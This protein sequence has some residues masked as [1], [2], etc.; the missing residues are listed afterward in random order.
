MSDRQLFAYLDG[1]LAGYFS[2]TA[3]G[4]LTFDYDD[5][6]RSRSGSTPLSLSMPLATTRHRKRA[7]LPWLEGLLPDSEEALRAL[8]SRFHTSSRNP[9]SLLEHVGAD[10]AGAVQLLPPGQDPSDS[11]PRAT[12]E[13]VSDVDVSGMLDRVVAEYRDGTPDASSA[14]RFSLAGAQ[15]KIALHRLPDGEW[16]VPQDATPTTHILKPVVGSFRR[17]DVVEQLTLRAAEHLGNDVSRA[18][19]VRIG[20]WDVLVSE[21]YDRRRA[22]DG[23]W[24]RVHQEDMCQALSV[25]PARKY[26]HRDGGPGLAQ[27]A[28]LLGSLPIAA[29]RAR[30]GAAFFRAFVFNIVAGCTD[31]HAK[32]FSL[33]LDGRTARLAPLYDLLTYAGY[34]DGSARID[35]AMSVAGEYSF[36]RISA[37]ALAGVGPRFGVAFDEAEELVASVRRDVIGAFDAARSA[38]DGHGAEATAV[39]DRVLRGLTRLPL[40]AP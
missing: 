4:N 36:H 32:N 9:F 30:A 10:A 1:R 39:A 16:G 40:V 24:H 15:P 35:S 11:G 25:S 21:R 14:G 31:A 8:G 28:Q 6:Y 23:L 22:E 33:I 7:A 26:Q 3:S 13:P 5:A 17:I 27:V 38:I 2:Q 20:D 18:E 37:P 19:I 29:D 34:W 12:V